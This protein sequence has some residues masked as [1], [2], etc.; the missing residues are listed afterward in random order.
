LWEHS[1]LKETLN[2]LHW[3]CPKII[4]TLH[5]I[6]WFC[7]CQYIFSCFDKQEKKKKNV[8]WD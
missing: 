8:M 1:G 7:M 2:I 6:T 3:A 4:L 5:K